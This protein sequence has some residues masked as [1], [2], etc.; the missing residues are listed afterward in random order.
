MVV[1]L[2][3]SSE[4]FGAD[5]TGDLLASV[6]AWLTARAGP[7]AVDAL[8]LALRKLAH[9]TEYAMLAVFW[10]LAFTGEAGLGSRRAALW[11]LGLCAG[12]AGL[13]E[14]RQSLTA[15]RTASLG[16]VAIDTAGAA[17]GMLAALSGG[18]GARVATAAGLWLAVTAGVALLVVNAL[19]GIPSGALWI[20]VSAAAV[21]LAARHGARGGA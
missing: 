16:D 18:R 17:I 21:A 2:S 7:A 14:A 4:R 15:N 12:W 11:A 8:H 1:I 5:Y 9:L 19:A 3:L 13:D 10:I 20:T 6:V